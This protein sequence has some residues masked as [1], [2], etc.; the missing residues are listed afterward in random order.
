MGVTSCVRLY[1]YAR[2]ESSFTQVTR[3]MRTALSSHGALDGFWPVDTE[4]TGDVPG[5]GAP[6]ALNCG[7][8]NGL[9][10]AHRA[11]AHKKHWLLLAP[12]SEGLP[13]GFARSLTAPSKILPEGLLT[14]GLLAPS[15]WAADVLSRSFAGKSVI[16]APHGVTPAIHRVDRAARASASIA[17]DKGRFDVLHMTSTEADRKSTKALLKAWKSLKKSHALPRAATLH[18]MMNPAYM[19]RLKWWMADLELT[20]GD[21]LTCPGLVSGQVDVAALYSGMHVI[22]QPSRAEGFGL[23]PLEALACGVPVVAT[24]CTGHSEYA[25]LPPAGFVAVE[26]GPSGPLDDFPGATAPTVS[27]GAIATALLSAYKGWE[28]LALLAEN[29]AEA[30]AAKWAW[31]K[32]NAAAIRQMIKEST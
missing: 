28:T 5:G 4:E 18:V 20:P 9:M 1:G 22:C 6:V 16:V 10:Q 24:T 15:A 2:G 3:G 29:S 14:G 23:V 7:D 17:F 13:H 19:S 8:P 11:G 25:A 12:N 21:V 32:T 30:L 31:E 27:E 26:H